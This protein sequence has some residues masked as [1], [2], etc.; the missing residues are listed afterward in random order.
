MSN[1]TFIEDYTRIEER[2]DD[3]VWIQGQE[4]TDSIWRFHDRSQMPGFLNLTLLNQ[5]TQVKIDFDTAFQMTSLL[6]V[7]H[8]FPIAICLNTDFFLI[9]FFPQ[10]PWRFVLSLYCSSKSFKSVLHQTAITLVRI[11]KN[12]GVKISV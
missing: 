4:D 3:F 12:P 5:I 6:T 9:W 7:T 11:K 1:F 8:L 2:V 10:I